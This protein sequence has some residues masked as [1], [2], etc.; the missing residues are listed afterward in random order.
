[1]FSVDIRWLIE[2]R[3]ILGEFCGDGDLD[4]CQHTLG[5]IKE[6]LDESTQPVQIVLN[7]SRV[8]TPLK[9]P[10]EMFMAANRFHQHPNIGQVIVVTENLAIRL[11]G[12]L[13]A[14]LLGTKFQAVNTMSQA[15]TILRRVDPSLD[16]SRRIAVA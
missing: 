15:F 5:R 1:M 9:D 13:L 7:M 11:S 12:R 8:S 2:D 6:L 14:Q 3:V 16:F 10:H 4:C